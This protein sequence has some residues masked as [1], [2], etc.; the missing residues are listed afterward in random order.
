ML[1]FQT[2]VSAQLLLDF[3]RKWPQ[4]LCVSLQTRGDHNELRNC[5]RMR[6]GS[7][8]SREKMEISAC[9]GL[10]PVVQ[11]V[12]KSTMYIWAARL[13]RFAVAE[14]TMRSPSPPLR[15]HPP[16]MISGR[17]QSWPTWT[18][19][20]GLII[21]CVILLQWP[22]PHLDYEAVGVAG[23][24]REPSLSCR[25]SEQRT[26]TMQQRLHPL[27]PAPTVAQAFRCRFFPLE[28]PQACLPQT[29]LPLSVSVKHLCEGPRRRNTCRP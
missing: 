10:C 12:A 6:F 14:F 27:L 15:S 28:V 26:A 16:V 25:C 29:R 5:P 20:S 13:Q 24:S 19:C 17:A 9:T 8:T 4:L 1:A 7:C 2:V 21:A 18:V 22:R 3:G 23:N 11:L